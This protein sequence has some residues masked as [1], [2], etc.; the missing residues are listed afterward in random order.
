MG[1]VTSGAAMRS[2]MNVT[3]Y[4]MCNAAMASM[5]YDGAHNDQP[6]NDYETIDTDTTPLAASF[7]GLSNRF[8]PTGRTTMVN[9][10][11]EADEALDLWRLNNKW[12]KP[13]NFILWGYGYDRWAAHPNEKLWY[14]NLGGLSYK[15]YLTTDAEAFGYCVQART[16]AAG[17]KLTVG[18]MD[19]T[20]DMGG[21]GFN[22]GVKHSAEWD[23]AYQNSYGFWKRMMEEFDEDVSN[24]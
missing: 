17:A 22:F 19:A 1:N 16:R 4:A 13:Y 2:G 5:A 24:R 6:D 8:N 7:W 18:N 23:R 10:A 11:L 12:F 9:F 14:G 15:R 3:R 20:V 21:V